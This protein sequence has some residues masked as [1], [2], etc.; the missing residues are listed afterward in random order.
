MKNTVPL[1][2]LLE[3]ETLIAKFYSP[4]ETRLFAKPNQEMNLRKTFQ[5]LKCSKSYLKVQNMQFVPAKTLKTPIVS[6][7]GLLMMFPLLKA[8]NQSGMIQLTSTT[9][10][11]LDKGSQK[12]LKNNSL[13]M[14]LTTHYQKKVPT[15]QAQKSI[16]NLFGQIELQLTTLN[17]TKLWEALSKNGYRLNLSLL[18]PS[19]LSLM[20]TKAQVHHLTSLPLSEEQES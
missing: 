1:K 19:L 9:S 7:H 6:S 11:L 10:E 18:N 12:I 17:I 5:E 8:L 3:L 20:L 14:E 4:P 15:S 16:L 2:T 13:L